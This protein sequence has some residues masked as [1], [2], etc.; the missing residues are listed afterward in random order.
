MKCIIISEPPLFFFFFFFGG[1]GGALVKA[2][3]LLSTFVPLLTVALNLVSAQFEATDDPL[4]KITTAEA[5]RTLI[6][7]Y[8]TS[9]YYYAASEK[10]QEISKVVS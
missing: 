10:V 8:H 3:T 9:Q 1:G 7:Y 2:C 5:I 6:E 4:E